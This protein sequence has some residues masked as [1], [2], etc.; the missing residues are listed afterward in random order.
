M[1]KDKILNNTYAILG[2]ARS[3]IGIARF[4]KRKGADVFISD[5]SPED[6]LLYLNKDILINEKIDFELNGHTDRVFDY[7]IIIKSPGIKPDSDIIKKALV[8]GKKVYSEIEVASWFCNVPIIAVTGTNGKTTTTVLIGEILAR[9]G[10]DVKVCGNVGLAF[11][12]VLDALNEKSVVVLETSSF[13]LYNTEYFRP[14]VAIVL[15]VTVDHLDWHGSF[16]NYFEAKTNINAKQTDDD[17]FIYNYDDPECKTRYAGRVLNGNVQAFSYDAEV[18]KYFRSGA[19]VEDNKI[20]YFDISK[21]IYLPIID[22]RDIYIKGKHNVQNAM[23]AILAAKVFQVTDDVIADTLK[24]FEGVEHRI[25]FVR[26]INGIKFYNDSK[27]TNFDSTYVALESFP[28]DIMLIMG[29]KKG[30]N[31]FARVDEYMSMRVKKI[32]AIGQ[33]KDAIYEHYS[34]IKEVI[35]CDSLDEAVKKA[36]A[37]S[38]S[39]DVVLFSPA[40]KSFD[41]FRNFEH[42]GEE[43]KKFVN[44]L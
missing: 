19:Y 31:N 22:V 11:S 12:E 6:A 14:K 20:I 44:N 39:G 1:D 3:G 9:H 16:H 41:M 32:Y 24:T 34:G 43:F 7:D 40:Y 35:K 29:G 18:K 21:Y 2:A 38:K 36:Y 27:A 17:Y 8:K 37:D 5:S 30:D 25:E 28:S 15:N 42:R 10:F 26:E 23:A 4:L 13:Q 33:S